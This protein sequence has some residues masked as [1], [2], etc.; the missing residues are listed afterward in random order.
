MK[1]QVHTNLLQQPSKQNVFHIST[2][3]NN[4]KNKNFVPL[5]FVNYPPGLDYYFSI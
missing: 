3:I 1:V 5:N 2:R 4:R